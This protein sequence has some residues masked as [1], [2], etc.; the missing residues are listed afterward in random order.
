M[1]DLHSYTFLYA[2]DVVVFSGP[3]HQLPANFSPIYF[4]MG[5]PATGFFVTFALLAG[6]V[7]AASALAGLNHIRSWTADSL[8]AAASAAVIAWSV[9]VLAFG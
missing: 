7:G 2:N 9:T 4:P 6:V 8:H 3:E 1:Y 5:N